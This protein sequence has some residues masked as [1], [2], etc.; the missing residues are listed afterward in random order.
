M[1]KIKDNQIFK[2][3]INEVTVNQEQFIDEI[4]SANIV[5]FLLFTSGPG[6]TQYN[7]SF[8]A[9]PLYEGISIQDKSDFISEFSFTNVE[10]FAIEWFS[11]IKKN[12]NIYFNNGTTLKLH[13]IDR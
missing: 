8:I 10:K 1:I 3:A 13:V 6:R 11:Q 12:Y 5:Q 9:K 7:G 4:T 2:E